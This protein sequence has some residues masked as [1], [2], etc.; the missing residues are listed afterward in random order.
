M[1]Q[2]C[3]LVDKV[4]NDHSLESM[5]LEVFSNLKDSMVLWKVVMK[6]SNMIM[7]LFLLSTLAWMFSD[8]YNAAKTA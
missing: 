7:F 5:T 3:V 2:C 8:R 6:C 1:A 4:G